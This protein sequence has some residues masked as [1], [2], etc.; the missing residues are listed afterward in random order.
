[1]NGLS[2]FVFDSM[3]ICKHTAQ[4]NAVCDRVSYF[5]SISSEEENLFNLL[6]HWTFIKMLEEQRL[7]I[8]I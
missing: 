1:M 4:I 6:V 5:S 7:N 8:P 2:Y 3:K